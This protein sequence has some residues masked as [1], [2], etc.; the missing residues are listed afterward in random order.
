MRTNGVFVPFS[1]QPSPVSGKKKV[2][3]TF[4]LP[5]FTDAARKP[6]VPLLKKKKFPFQQL[7]FTNAGSELPMSK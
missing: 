6:D 3:L 5:L 1:L 7:N 4:G 2:I